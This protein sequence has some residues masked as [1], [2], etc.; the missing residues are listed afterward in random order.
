MTVSV[1]LPTYNEVRHGLLDAILANLE[2]APWL[3][4]IAVDGGST[5]GTLEII[6]RFPGIKILETGPANRAHRLNR[7]AEIAKGEVIFLHHPRSLPEIGALEWLRD[8]HASVSWG[9]LTHKFDQDHP[10][11]AFTSWYS[12]G[13]RGRLGGI[14]YLDHC[15]FV[16]RRLW[17]PGLLPEVDVF[18]DSLLCRGLKRHSKPEIL[19][20]LSTTSATR[21]RKNG[22]WRQALM[23]QVAKIAFLAGVP[24]KLINRI[25]EHG[26]DFNGKVPPPKT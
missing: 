14:V 23:N 9:G 2:R 11:L 16:H 10:L 13:V 12:N 7:G 8:N 24:P 17:H 25:Y 4:V 1:V 20:F 26:L 22:L 3:E 15:L 19:T 18:E 6:R 5:D 21:F